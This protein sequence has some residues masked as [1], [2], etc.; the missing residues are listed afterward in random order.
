MIETLATLDI[1]QYGVGAVFIAYLIKQNNGLTSALNG[2]KEAID[3]DSQAT[4]RLEQAF[5]EHTIWAKQNSQFMQ[6]IIASN[7]KTT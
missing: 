2:L 7:H 3:H 4:T 1:V 6:T 5:R